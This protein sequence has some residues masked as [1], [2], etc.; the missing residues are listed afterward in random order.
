MA[1]EH[2]LKGNRIPEPG[3]LMRAGLRNAFA[4][5]LEKID[6]DKCKAEKGRDLVLNGTLIDDYKQTTLK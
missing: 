6:D 4:A 2:A 3:D 5:Y 1:L